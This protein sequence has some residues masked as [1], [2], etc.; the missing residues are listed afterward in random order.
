[1]NKQAEEQIAVVAQLSL[2]VEV[3]DIISETT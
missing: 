2:Y 1:M 3:A